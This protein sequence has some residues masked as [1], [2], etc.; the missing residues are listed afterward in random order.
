MS[1]RPKRRSAYAWRGWRNST[2]KRAGR[3]PSCSRSQ[4]PLFKF[5]SP[6]GSGLD[7]CLLR[8]K[9]RPAVRSGSIA[10]LADRQQRLVA[11]ATTRGRHPE[12]RRRTRLGVLCYGAS[13]TIPLR[14]GDA[15]CPR[16]HLIWTQPLDA[17][18][19]PPRRH[20][21]RVGFAIKLGTVRFLGPFRPNPLDVPTDVLVYQAGPLGLD[22]SGLRA[23][24]ERE[25]TPLEH[26]WETR[27]EYGYRGFAEA[28]EEL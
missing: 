10:H 19:A 9:R 8:R 5:H 25:M 14:A 2:L 7:R 4:L 24:A 3:S 17:P 13:E 16:P 1:S 26:A 12:S 22:V 11:E 27:R 21:N 28:E 23:Y 15:P 20:P 18:L 6:P